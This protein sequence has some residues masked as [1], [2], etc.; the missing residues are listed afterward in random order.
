MSSVSILLIQ[1]RRCEKVTDYFYGRLIGRSQLYG[2]ASCTNRRRR[3]NQ[4]IVRP[5]R[6]TRVAAGNHKAAGIRQQ[7]P[8][9][10]RKVGPHRWSVGGRR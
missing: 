1:L 5:L 9:S 10:H 4:P 3:E 2:I 6:V 8:A 7:Y